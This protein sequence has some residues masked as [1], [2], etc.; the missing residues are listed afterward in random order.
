[1]LTSG[2]LRFVPLLAL[3][4]LTRLR[5]LDLLP[6]FLDETLHVRWALLI[7]QGD[8]S[9]DATWKWGR[10]LTIWLGAL[11]SPWASDLLH[12]NRLLSVALGAV[13]LVATVEIARRL[14]GPRPA[15]SRASSTCS[16]PSRSS[17]TGWRSRRPASPPSRP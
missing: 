13:T 3:H 17:T 6:I 9:W 4:L 16:A 7:A 5:G 15:F 1:M 14:L 11:V 10:A 8:K 2:R 12:A